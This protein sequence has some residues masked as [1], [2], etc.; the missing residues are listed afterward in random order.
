MREKFVCKFS[1]CIWGLCHTQPSLLGN[2]G[3]PLRVPFPLQPDQTP[4]CTHC[5][6]SSSPPQH[7]MAF[8]FISP[9]LPQTE[10]SRRAEALLWAPLDAWAQLTFRT[11]WERVEKQ[12]RHGTRASLPPG[13]K[14]PSHLSPVSHFPTTSLCTWV[15]KQDYDQLAPE[16][17]II[18]KVLN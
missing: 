14:T 4:Y 15:T 13:A 8:P 1:Q 7:F 12:A 3:L 10:S 16:G 11:P 17:T 9:V 5:V 6:P 18:G 2:T